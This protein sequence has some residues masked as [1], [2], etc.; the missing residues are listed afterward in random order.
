MERMKRWRDEEDLGRNVTECGANGSRREKPR[1]ATNTPE[2]K[3]TRSRLNVER[4]S[5]THIE[6][7]SSLQF[8]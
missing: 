1:G 5:K 2:E 4:L 6:C 3:K 8:S 7:A